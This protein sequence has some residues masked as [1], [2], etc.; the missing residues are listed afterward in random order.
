GGPASVQYMA[1]GERPA[2]LSAEPHPR[3]QCRLAGER[4]DARFGPGRGRTRPLFAKHFVER[5]LHLTHELAKLLD[6]PLFRLL[7][8]V[9]DHHDVLRGK[10]APLPYELVANVGGGAGQKEPRVKHRL[11]GVLPRS[12]G[13]Q[14]RLSADAAEERRVE[15]LEDVAVVEGELLQPL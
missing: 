7:S 5:G 11:D 6:H 3:V 8:I 15:V 13:G 1:R 12:P 9:I 2:T 14:R 10:L 4:L